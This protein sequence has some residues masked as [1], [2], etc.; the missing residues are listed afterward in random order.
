MRNEFQLSAPQLAQMLSGAEHWTQAHVNRW[1][2]GLERVPNAI[3]AKAEKLHAGLLRYP[4]GKLDD[5]AVVCGV[6]RSGERPPP[7]EGHNFHAEEAP[8]PG[9]RT[10]VVGS[11]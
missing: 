9:L 3:A 7:R 8:P 5:V 11:Q 10:G 2:A 1:E 6:V 4:G